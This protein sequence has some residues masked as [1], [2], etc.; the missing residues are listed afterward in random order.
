[1]ALPKPKREDL[2]IVLVGDF[3][4]KIFQPVWFASEG[5]IKQSESDDADIEIIRPEISAF[6]L[7]WLNLNVTRDRFIVETN[8]DPY[9]DVVRD[10]IVGT[11]RTLS[12]TPIKMMGINLRRH[13]KMPSERAWHQ[14]GDI[15][16][17]KGIWEGILEKPGMQ[18]LSMKAL[19]PDDHQ[20]HILLTTGPEEE[21]GNLYVQVNDHF[22]FV[23]KLADNIIG[24]TKAIDL[25][26]KE[27]AQQFPLAQ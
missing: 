15:L 18:T 6:K 12:H 8:K 3:N 22:S 26:E 21:T 5:L 14:F 25:L 27:W 7:D 1:M 4:P 11:F 20:G 9:F 23:E 17:P 13:Y 16:A 10:L 2:I 24:C 19:R